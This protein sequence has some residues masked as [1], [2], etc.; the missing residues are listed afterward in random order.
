M[1]SILSLVDVFHVKPA[2]LLVIPVDV[3]IE[4][5]KGSEVQSFCPKRGEHKDA[6]IRSMI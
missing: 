6:M 2:T 1:S 5:V 3:D 4:K